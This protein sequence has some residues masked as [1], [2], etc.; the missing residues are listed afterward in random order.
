MILPLPVV[1]L[2]ALADMWQVGR[3]HRA[4][5]KPL[6]ASLDS[7]A[8]AAGLSVRLEAPP[9][10]ASGASS[11]NGIASALKELVALRESGGLSEAEFEAAKARLLAA[12]ADFG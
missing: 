11:G 3:F 7:E 1:I 2:F 8:R 9:V 4:G 6:L 10:A 12:D 5:V